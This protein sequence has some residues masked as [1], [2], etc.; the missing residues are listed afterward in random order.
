MPEHPILRRRRLAGRLVP[1]ALAL[2]LAVAACRG[3]A[4]DR[5]ANFILVT[6]DTTRA[7]FVGAYGLDEARTPALDAL[8][9]EGIL[10]EN[11]QTLVPI[12]LPSHASLFFSEPPHAVENYNNGQAILGS[13]AR[14]SL[15]GMFRRG[16]FETGAFVSLGVLASEYGLD[17]GF[18]TYVDD[19]PP[20]RWYLT[21][22]EVNERVL[23]WLEARK[24][25]GFF[26]WVHYSDPHEPYA[27]PGTPDDLRIGLEGGPMGSYCL[28]K[29][30]ILS[31]GLDL[32]RGTNR[33]LFE[34]DSPS[35]RWRG[36]YV[37]QLKSFHLLPR[38]GLTVSFPGDTVFRRD[39]GVL[40]LK[41]RGV[42]EILCPDGPRTATLEVRGKLNASAPDLRDAYRREMEYMDGEVGRLVAAL[43]KLGLYERTAV[44]A[45][46]DHG[47]GLGEYLTATGNRHFGHIHFLNP[48]YMKVPFILRLPGGRAKGTRR[49]EMVTL[50][51]VAPTTAA[52]MGLDAPGPWRGRDLMRL[53]PGTEMPVFQETYKPE[54]VHF[55][56]GL[57]D[58]ARH[59]IFTPETGRYEYFDHADD[60]GEKHAVTLEDGFPAAASELKQRLDAFVRDVLRNKKDIAFDDR[61]EEMLRSLGYVGDRK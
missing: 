46:G 51:D 22:G 26:L 10:F 59:L 43:R 24:G 28:E 16:G 13:V 42:I 36:P 15:A 50:L 32:A 47:E 25:R 53:A 34:V 29:G 17:A 52:L 49:P 60:P 45:V 31:V 27:P 56:F 18:E 5:P 14:R 7:D 20:D 3:K 38:D 21:A 57:L 39:D 8:A 33:L 19:F 58:R 12:T 9:A 41:E 55:K 44:L 37:A 23:P 40:F 11:A 6:L 1:A 54:A 2:V 30:A 48:V 4:G 61:A 35:P